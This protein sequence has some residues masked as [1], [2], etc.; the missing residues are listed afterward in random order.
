MRGRGGLFWRWVVAGIVVL[1]ALVVGVTVAVAQAVAAT[2]PW[3]PLVT[4]SGVVAVAGM[5]G[6]W[7]VRGWRQKRTEQ[8]VARHEAEIEDLKRTV[9]RAVPREEMEHKLERIEDKVGQGF[10][11]LRADLKQLFTALGAERR[12]REG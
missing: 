1:M 12:A 10:A 5:V 8:D 2:S 7:A 4:W 6:E 9:E 11:E 3:A